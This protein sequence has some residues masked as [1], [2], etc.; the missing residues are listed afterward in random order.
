VEVHQHRKH[1]KQRDKRGEGGAKTR[2]VARLSATRRS[3]RPRR[4]TTPQQPCR[5]KRGDHHH[6]PMKHSKRRMFGTYDQGWRH[7]PYLLKAGLPACYLVEQQ[8]ER[9][10]RTEMREEPAPT[11]RRDVI[12]SGLGGEPSA[13]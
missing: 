7:A 10:R 1:R 6:S 12:Q 5:E 2:P 8:E 4:R 13:A 3:S 11:Q 9:A